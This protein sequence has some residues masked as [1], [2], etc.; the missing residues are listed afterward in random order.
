MPT[1]STVV[2]IAFIVVPAHQRL[3]PLLLPQSSHLLYKLSHDWHDLFE[4]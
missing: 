3:P 4:N 2:V 1:H